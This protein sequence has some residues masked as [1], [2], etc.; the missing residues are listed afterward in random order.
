[1]ANTFKNIKKLGDQLAIHAKEVDGL[2]YFIGYHDRGKCFA[3]IAERI[4]IV[5]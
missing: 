4:P 3:A 5:R 2:V 1:M